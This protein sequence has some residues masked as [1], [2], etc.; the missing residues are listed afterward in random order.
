[1]QMSVNCTMC[2]PVCA[3]GQDAYT[4]TEGEELHVRVLVIETSLQSTHGVLG[5]GRLGANLVAYF[6]VERD[7]L[8]TAWQQFRGCLVW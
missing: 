3:I 6:E 4:Y 8:G 7:V 1:M 5:L 2:Q